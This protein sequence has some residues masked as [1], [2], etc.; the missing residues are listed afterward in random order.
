MGLLEW[1]NYQAVH[2]KSYQQRLIELRE[3]EVKALEI[4]AK[5]SKPPPDYDS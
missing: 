1:L 5:I 3:R 4:I 2:H